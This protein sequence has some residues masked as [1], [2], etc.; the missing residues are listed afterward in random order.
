MDLKKEAQEWYAQGF[1]VVAVC[2]ESSTEGKVNKKPLVEWSRWISRRQ[3]AQ[4]FE[5]QPW[6]R[7]DGFAVICSYPSFNGLFLAVVDFD[8]KNVKREAAE[9]GEKLLKRFPTTKIERTISGGL[10]YVYLSKVR[11]NPVTQCHDECALELVSGSRLCIMAPSKGYVA[12]NDNSPRVIEDAEGL[13]YEVLGVTDPRE[14]RSGANDSLLQHWLNEVRQH[15]NVTGEGPNY[16][17]VHCPFHPPDKHPSFA[18]HK[19]KFY[20]VD[21]HDGRVYSLKELASA[22]GLEFSSETSVALDRYILRVKGQRLIVYNGEKP[23]YATPLRS[24][25]SKKT[26]SD[27]AE[28]LAVDRRSLEPALAQLLDRLTDPKEITKAQTNNDLWRKVLHA[29]LD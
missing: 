28:Y 7:A 25:L 1:N 15:L 17:Y 18:I 14:R 26:K 27:L 20:A 11:V 4:E 9:R 23:I 12:L 2:F 8:T 3:E 10:H 6:D 19:T 13:F 5:G 24:I 21:Y 29:D 22:L 16:F